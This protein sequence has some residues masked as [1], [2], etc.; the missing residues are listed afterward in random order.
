MHIPTFPLIK[1][2]ILGK[3]KYTSHCQAHRQAQLLKYNCIIELN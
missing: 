1:L 3:E 2:Q